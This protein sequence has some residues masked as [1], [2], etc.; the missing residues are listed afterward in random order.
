VTLA[1]SMENRTAESMC[2]A[3]YRYKGL[4]VGQREFDRTCFGSIG[5]TEMVAP[6]TVGDAPIGFD[7]RCKP[8]A[9]S[10]L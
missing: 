1:T 8:L 7:V 3:D 9:T 4:I 10:N 6:G 2:H 5:D